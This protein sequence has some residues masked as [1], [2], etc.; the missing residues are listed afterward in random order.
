MF[1]LRGICG[2][3]CS[4]ESHVWEWRNLYLQHLQTGLWTLFI[5]IH[6]DPGSPV[7]MPILIFLNFAHPEMLKNSD[8]SYKQLCIQ[9][10][11]LFISIGLPEIP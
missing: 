5:A 8:R 7:Q 11:I 4:L 6:P 9:I 3:H 2:T 10:L 1:T